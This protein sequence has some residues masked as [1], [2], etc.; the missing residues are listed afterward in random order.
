MKTDGHYKATEG[1][2]R[3]NNL[4]CLHCDFVA[5]RPRFGSG[6][7]KYNKMRGEIVKHLHSEHRG[8][9]R[10]LLFNKLKED[11]DGRTL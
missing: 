8:I 9:L 6:M 3:I 11:N 10:G 7:A 4:Y 2:Y 1:L 5:W